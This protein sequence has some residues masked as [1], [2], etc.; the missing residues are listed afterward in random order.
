MASLQQASFRPSYSRL[1]LL[2]S[3][4]P[5]FH[6]RALGLCAFGF[7][8]TAHSSQMASRHP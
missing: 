8:I 4:T 2:I 1:N 5:I 3:E 6:R 7:K